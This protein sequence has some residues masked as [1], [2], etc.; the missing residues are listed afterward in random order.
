MVNYAILSHV[1]TFNAFTLKTQFQAFTRSVS[2]LNGMGAHEITVEVF[3][4]LSG[5]NITEDLISNFFRRFLDV[6]YEQ[7]YLP[8]MHIFSRC[9]CNLGT[10]QYLEDRESFGYFDKEVL[11][12]ILNIIQL[13]QDVKVMNTR[14]YGGYVGEG[15]DILRSITFSCPYSSNRTPRN[16]AD[17][18]FY[19]TLLSKLKQDSLLSEANISKIIQ[20]VNDFG[21][22]SS[23]LE[24]MGH[25]TTLSQSQLD[26]ILKGYSRL[27]SLPAYGD[28][29]TSESLPAYRP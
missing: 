14:G 13:L 21:C 16:K 28:A 9:D 4:K 2:T 19:H 1:R 11:N 8:L 26:E 20:L 7:E 24:E 12:Y 5:K 10:T 17:L 6:R 22:K 3:K 27:P 29:D 18:N 23:V 15:T 25:F